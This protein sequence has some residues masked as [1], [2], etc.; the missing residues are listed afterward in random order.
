MHTPRGAAPAHVPCPPCCPWLALG[1][2]RP[3]PCVGADLR[4]PAATSEPVGVPEG[5]ERGQPRCGWHL[6]AV[7]GGLL[8]SPGLFVTCVFFRILERAWFQY[9]LSVALPSGKLWSVFRRLWELLL[10]G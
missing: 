8:A 10:Q 5:R 4:E 1:L 2:C 3:S 9:P 7:S 6:E